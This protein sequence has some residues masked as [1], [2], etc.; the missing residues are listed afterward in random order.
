MARQNPARP[1]DRETPREWRRQAGLKHREIDSPIGDGVLDHGQ[2]VAQPDLQMELS[3][4]ISHQ[5]GGEVRARQ[6]SPGEFPHVPEQPRAGTPPDQEPTP[7][8]D[9]RR[10]LAAQANPG[11]PP[12]LR[13]PFLDTPFPGPA[14]GSPGADKTMRV[15][16]QAHRCP[17]LYQC[18][19]EVPGPAAGKKLLSGSRQDS[20]QGRFVGV[21]LQTEQV[22]SGPAQHCHPG[23]PAAGRKQ[24]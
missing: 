2:P 13:Q 14:M 17:Q 8:P 21:S 10:S 18:L 23:Q 7:M 22:G 1:W 24:Y 12:F 16:G 19:V 4:E 9:H 15:A 5:G 20:L 6:F 11:P 3:F